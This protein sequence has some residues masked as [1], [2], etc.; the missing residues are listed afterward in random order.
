MLKA[1]VFI[2]M[3]ASAFAQGSTTGGFSTGNRWQ[4]WGDE[5]KTAYLVGVSEGLRL[6]D[7]QQGDVVEASFTDTISFVNDYFSVKEN[8]SQAIV[9]V[10]ALYARSQAPIMHSR[11]SSNTR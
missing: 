10:L 6:P 4:T 11:S 3:C 1:F 7:A 8:R 2:V 5:A 9:Y